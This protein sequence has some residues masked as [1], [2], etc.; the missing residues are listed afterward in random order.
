MITHGH[1]DH[2][3]GIPAI[4]EEFPNARVLYQRRGQCKNWATRQKN[5]SADFGFGLTLETGPRKYSPMG[6]SIEVAGLT[7]EVRFYSRPL[8]RARRFL[9]FKGLILRSYSSET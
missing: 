9:F 1:G 6:E 8:V 2:I 5:L 3:G 4:K 7:F